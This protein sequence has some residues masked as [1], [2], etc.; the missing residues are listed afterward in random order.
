M[1]V[2]CFDLDDTLCKEIDYLSSA[3]R[4]IAKYATAIA[5]KDNAVE[6]EAYLVMLEAYEHGGN[7]FECLNTYLGLSL[8]IAE[9]LRIYRYHRTEVKMTAEAAKTLS[10]LKAYGCVLGLITDGRSVQQRNKIKALGLSRWFEPDN[11]IISEEFGSQK[12][13][14]ANYEY[15]MKRYP[16]A[17]YMYVGDNPKKDFVGANTLG[18]CTVCLLDDGRNIHK[19]DFDICQQCQPQVII[20]DIVEILDIVR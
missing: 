10:V 6:N 5:G 17:M 12:P 13:S 8:P 2:I 15:F 4:E 14:L 18:W 20:K 3:Y 1:K 19:Q 9:Y 16:R 11:I 7:A